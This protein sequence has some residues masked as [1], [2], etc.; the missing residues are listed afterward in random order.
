[1]KESIAKEAREMAERM[2]ELLDASTPGPWA[3]VHGQDRRRDRVH[4]RPGAIETEFASGKRV[5]CEAVSGADKAF[6]LYAR[7]HFGRV[8]ELLEMVAGQAG[9]AP[10]VTAAPAAPATEAA[11]AESA[12]EAPSPASPTEIDMDEHI[13][14]D[15]FEIDLS[16]LNG[17]EADEIAETLKNLAKPENGS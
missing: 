16:E 3:G 13:S 7:N 14:G 9:A 10:S 11:P 1:M 17:D 8:A 15:G 2:R 4:A 6:I 12:A 5:V